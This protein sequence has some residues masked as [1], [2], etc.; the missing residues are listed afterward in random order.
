M[1]RYCIALV[2]SIIYLGLNAQN[3]RDSVTSMVQLHNQGYDKLVVDSGVKVDSVFYRYQYKKQYYYKTGKLLSKI[4]TDSTGKLLRSYLLYKNDSVIDG[5]YY[6]FFDNG[7]IEIS[8]TYKGGVLDGKTIVF[9]HEEINWLKLYRK[10]NLVYEMWFEDGLL[11]RY[12]GF[13]GYF[14]RYN[15]YGC[16]GEKGYLTADSLRLNNGVYTSYYDDTDECNILFGQILYDRGKTVRYL[17]FVDK[18]GYSIAKST[19]RKGNGKLI[20]YYDKT[21]KQKRYVSTFK[22]GYLHGKSY[23]YDEKG[24]LIQTTNYLYGRVIY[25]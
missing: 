12:I 14:E 3:Q 5:V 22:D 21:K 24:N 8:T 6:T 9:Y 7:S 23:G 20:V 19:V 13:D 1:I 11:R 25:Q 10:G 18:Q 4:E 17:K 15:Y 2:L 16:I